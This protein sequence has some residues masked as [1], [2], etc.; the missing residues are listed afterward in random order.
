S[1][2]RYNLV[3]LLRSEARRK[4]REARYMAGQTLLT[5]DEPAIPRSLRTEM[6]RALLAE[7]PEPVERRAFLLWLGRCRAT[8]PLAEALGLAEA[9]AREQEA[10]VKRFKDRITKRLRRHLESKRG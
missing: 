1:S 3:D 8:K 9:S 7:I 4:A 5:S 6:L 2:A 10:E